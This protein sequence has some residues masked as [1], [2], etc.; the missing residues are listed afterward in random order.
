MGFQAD[1]RAAAITTLEAHASAI[2]VKLATYPGRPASLKPPHA[3]VDLVSEAIV[4][5]G[6]MM[7]RTVTVQ[8]VMLYGSFDSGEAVAGRD[9]FIDGYIDY[10]RDNVHAAGARPSPGGGP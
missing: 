4:Y 2:S 8:V 7:Q 1:C 5:V 10:V 3:F 6:H 9:A